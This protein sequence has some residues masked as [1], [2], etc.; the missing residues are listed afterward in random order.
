MRRD[1][2]TTLKLDGDLPLVSDDLDTEAGWP[3]PQPLPGGLLP[4]RPFNPSMLPA[5][6]QG[7]VTDIA[8][9]LSCPPDLVGIPAMVAAG[10]MIGRKVAIRPQRNTNWMEVGNLWGCVVA[11]PGSL[12]SP[13]ALEALRPI[14]Q[15]EA[16]AAQENDAALQKHK[17]EEALF[18][19]EQ[20]AAEKS[21]RQALSGKGTA[22]GRDAALSF[23]SSA[24]GPITP[25]IRRYLTSDGT[26]EKLGEI[27]KDNPNGIMVH[28]D[29]LLSL[30][31][32]LDQ[33]K[34]STARGFYL[35]AWGGEEGYI[36]DRIGRG[37]IRI[38]AVNISLFGTTQPNRLSNY[39]RESL[40]NLDDGMVQRLQLLAWPDFDD[41]FREV[42]RFPDTAAQQAAQDCFT[43]LAGMDAREIGAVFE[44]AADPFEVPF[45]RFAED[46]QEV[47]SVWRVNLEE[48][49]RGSELSNSL[50]AH[51]A[52]YRGLIPRL[53][54]VCHIANNDVGPVS[55]RAIRQAIEWAGYL[56]SHACRAYASISTDYSDTARMLW[57]KIRRGQLSSEFTSREIAR[58]CWTGLA[59]K[60]LVEGALATLRDAGWISAQHIETGGRPTTLYKPNPIALKL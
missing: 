49:V 31:S 51:L 40:R 57:E 46:A 16:K 30:F 47:F 22:I 52:K 35:T 44:E 4:V 50:K 54:L 27:C 60:G 19:F 8:E 37:T 36:F 6:L 15:L 23:L 39:V 20:E 53:A 34:N 9:R 41:P 1:L 14:K 5:Q 26:T 55:L 29:E 18:K 48:R 13:A 11:P 25:P 43:R 21:A 59:D 7:W 32:D 17:A 56:E 12:K 10:A 3:S 33:P 45:L 42:D 24:N 28:R 58:K 38:P 2:E